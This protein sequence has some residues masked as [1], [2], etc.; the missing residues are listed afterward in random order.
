MYLA[1]QSATKPLETSRVFFNIVTICFQEHITFMPL[2]FNNNN[3]KNKWQNNCHSMHFLMYLTIS[4][5]KFN[6][7]VENIDIWPNGPS[8]QFKSKFIFIYTGVALH[9]HYPGDTMK[10]QERFR[11]SSNIHTNFFYSTLNTKNNANG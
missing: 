10:T 3:D 7:V 6:K 4:K 1:R 8:S 9:S 5:Q 11:Q 2:L